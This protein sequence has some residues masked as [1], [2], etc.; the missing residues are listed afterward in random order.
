ME[1]SKINFSILNSKKLLRKG[2][3]L[4]GWTT[5]AKDL[6][7]PSTYSPT[8][9]TYKVLL[10]FRTMAR[11][12]SEEEEIVWIW[13]PKTTAKTMLKRVCSDDIYR[14]WIFVDDHHP[15]THV[16][17]HHLNFKEIRRHAHCLQKHRKHR[18]F[19]TSSVF[20]LYQF[21][22]DKNFFITAPLQSKRISISK[23]QR[24][25]K[26]KNLNSEKILNKTLEYSVQ[27]VVVIFS[28]LT[29]IVWIKFIP[30]KVGLL[31]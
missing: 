19:Q 24:N 15:S 12:R 3:S 28:S 26:Y 13:A 4:F 27:R 16:N 30:K 25:A 7:T 2:N 21:M 31:K 22:N 29:N 18:W 17:S 9:R 8:A 1:Y 14:S 11:R 23:V 20:H 6:W 10:W 5:Q